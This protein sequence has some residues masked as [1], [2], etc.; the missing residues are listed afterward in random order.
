VRLI[1][2]CPVAHRAW[3]LPHWFACLAAQT[4]RPDAFAFIHSGNVGDETWAAIWSEAHR[5]DFHEI[6]IRHDDRW[7]HPRH[8][9]QRFH[10]LADLRNQMLALVHDELEADLLLSLDTDVMLENPGTIDHLER[11][12]MADQADIAAPVT[13]FHPMGEDSWAFNAGWWHPG[14]R[15]SD[16]RRPWKR[17]DPDK[18]PWG[19]V[20]PI[21]IPM[22]VW[23]G[24]RHAMGCRYEWHESGEDLGFGQSIEREH[25][26]CLW[27]TDLRC[28]HAWD[29]Q[30]L[31]DRAVYRT[32]A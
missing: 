28:F 20:I 27:D 29:E 10:T 3:S 7:P 1:V 13:W 4:R 17:M 21:D 22:G 15:N 6:T 2:G 32:A 5:H 14:G 23:V 8:D 19:D 11:I 30:H 16:P 12:V 26:R 24:N 25:I 18:V 9:N 31:A